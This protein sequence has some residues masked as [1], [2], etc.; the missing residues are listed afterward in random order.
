M[1]VASE[2]ERR[3]LRSSMLLVLSNKTIV[4]FS[5]ENKIVSGWPLIYVNM[6]SVV[7]IFISRSRPINFALSYDLVLI[8]MG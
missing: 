4:F 8:H 5:P 6:S 2:R 7:T 1:I 3:Y